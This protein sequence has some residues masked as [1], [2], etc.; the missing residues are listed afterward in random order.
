[1]RFLH[2]IACAA[3]IC[4]AGA[5][6]LPAGDWTR[7]AEAD[8]DAMHDI[9]QDNHPGP[10]DTLNPGFDD[11]LNGGRAQLMPMARAARSAADYRLV[12]RDY[13][14]GFADG[15][16]GL[17]FPEAVPHVWPGFLIRA[18]APGGPVRVS[19]ADAG[20]GA[21]VGDVLESC[22]GIPAA[23]L[24]QDRV[25]RPLMNPHVPQRLQLRSAWLMVADTDDA[26]SQYNICTFSVGGARRS[27]RLH[28]R[29]IDAAALDL[30]MQASSG[31]D[32]P[33]PGLR[34]IGGTW[35][36][37]LPTFF[38]QG[39]QLRQMQDTIADVRAKVQTL[40]AARHVVIDLR[41]NDGGSDD[42]GDDV[43]GALWG[44]QAVNAID[45]SMS[46]KVDW[47][48]SAR[49]A[50][51]LRSKAARMRGDRQS[52]SAQYFDAIAAR[53]EKALRAHQVFMRETD[54]ASA[55]LPRFVSPFAH[56]VYVLTT[57]HC[58][59]ACLDFLDEVRHLP[60]VVL[61]GLET[62]SDTDYLEIAE[63]A[64]PSGHAT[65]H[66]AMKVFRERQRAANES[67]KPAIGWPGGTMT[68]ASVAAWIGRLP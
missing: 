55:S 24:L 21:R 43:A 6:P 17:V 9:I 15:H 5:A 8:I 54:P 67:Y 41:G 38:P 35:L 27:V 13:A 1:M 14:N 2:P 26:R 37:S 12:L 61:V 60:G 29:P 68:D 18:D 31:I 32:I 36:I 34:Q 4:L 66:Y 25:V 44:A 62:S 40:H 39:E 57:P 23:R 7:A 28:W 19:V 30:K 48:V 56:P 45:A 65:L 20:A 3:L 59:S 22:G 53:M 46:F 50:A 16:L 11:W 52:D 42:W 47:R 10:V 58:A 49:N 64:L 33:R 51:A 63:A